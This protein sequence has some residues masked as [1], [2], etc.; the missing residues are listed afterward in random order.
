MLKRANPDESEA[1]VLMRALRE[2]NI[3]KIVADDM[4]VFLTLVSDLFPSVAPAA[5]ADSM[6]DSSLAVCRRALVCD[7]LFY[8]H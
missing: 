3:P 5:K 1:A 6:L 7:S 8:F 2:F 4:G